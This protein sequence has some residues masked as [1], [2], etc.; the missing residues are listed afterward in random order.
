MYLA[1]QEIR[2]S[3]GR[4][5]AISAVVFLVSYLVYFLTGLAWGLA[6]SYTE[7]VEKWESDTVT[8]TESAN[9]NILASRFNLDD[10]DYDKD[11]SAPIVVGSAAI[12]ESPGSDDLSNV[13]IYGID[14]DS[15]LAPQVT[16]GDELTDSWQ[17]VADSTLKVDGYSIGDTIS[18]PDADKD[19]TIVGFA[20]E[21][22]FQAAPVLF[23]PLQDYGDL[24][25]T[26]MPD[27]PAAPGEQAEEPTMISAMI[28]L[29]GATTPQVDTDESIVTISTDDFI[30]EL[31]GYT[32]QYMTFALMIGALIFI[33]SLVLGIFM[34]VM[35]LQKKHIFGIMKAQGV[36]TGY[37][38]RAGAFQ[39]LFIT[40]V[41]VVLGLIIAAISGTLLSNTVPFKVQPLLFGAVT[42]GFIVFTVLGSL[43][44]IRVIAKI[45]PIKAI[46]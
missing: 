27:I 15:F 46:D 12:A 22:R 26:Q 28:N 25:A 33:L 34:Y 20:D 1:F 30:Q 38:A 10:V 45:D 43:F 7:S 37:I 11:A 3:A 23:V 16:E 8:M 42:A 36:P 39:T 19:I 31:P 4:F 41:G 6:S 9:K 13:F 14:P 21:Q 40:L 2:H 17:V 5:V 29:P 44:P 24:T 18:L 35:T 32:E